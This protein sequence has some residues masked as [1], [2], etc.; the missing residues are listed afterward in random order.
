VIGANRNDALHRTKTGASIDGKFLSK[1]PIFANFIA[2][3]LY[4]PTAIQI[5]ARAGAKS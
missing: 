4:K 1:C 5:M 2:S 3:R